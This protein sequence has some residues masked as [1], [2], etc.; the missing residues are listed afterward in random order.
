MGST[1]TAMLWLGG[2]VAVADI[3]DSR[4]YLLR[5]RALRQLPWASSS[6]CGSATRA[7]D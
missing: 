5:G 4:G 6:G 3:G 2:H 1:L 7:G